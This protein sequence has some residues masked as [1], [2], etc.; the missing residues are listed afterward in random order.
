[1]SPGSSP[2][3]RHALRTAAA[4]A[5]LVALALAA[6]LAATDLLVA[7][8][9]TA[10]V[11]QRLGQWLDAVARSTGTGLISEG[12]PDSDF[13]EPLLTW[14]APPGDGCRPVGTAPPLPAA[15]CA[16]GGPAG[17]TVHGVPFRLLGRR[18]PDGGVVVAGESMA[19]VAHATGELVL[20]ELVVG[21]V[22]LI[23]VFLG[24][25]AIGRRVG[26]SV[27]RMRRRQLAFTADASHELRT[28]LSVM[29]AEAD[30]ALAGRD[31]DLRPALGRVSGEIG[32]MR[33]LVDD[34]LWLA[35]FDSEPAPPAP[36]ELDLVTAARLTAERFSAVAS[37]RSLQLVIEAPDTVLPITIAPEWLDRLGGV[38][39][40]NACRHAASRVTV[41]VSPRSGRRVELSVAN[42]GEGIPESDLPLIFDRFHRATSRG[43]GAGLGLAIADSIVRASAG[44]WEITPETG[45][46][47]RFAVVW[48]LARTPGPVRA[49]SAAPPERRPRAHPFVRRSGHAA[50]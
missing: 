6:V 45:G 50:R 41:A 18:L 2:L 21:P 5:A 39:V 35:R 43:E 26:G 44:R 42:D 17:A 25:L 32:R 34:L 47:V 38:L 46:G 30:V 8:N 31:R 33:R 49:T 4:A 13:D 1:M 9:L 36:A 48:P 40:D 20:A 7:H 22:L 12:A 24:S 28:P 10:S 19:P 27:E 15:L 14:Q 3:N 16:P 23:L 37:G 11:D 29:Q